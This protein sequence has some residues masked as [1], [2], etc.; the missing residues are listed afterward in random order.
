MGC[1][2]ALFRCQTV[3][4]QLGDAF[5]TSKPSFTH[6][7]GRVKP[8]FHHK[9]QNS[10]KRIQKAKILHTGKN[11]LCFMYIY[12]YIHTVTGAWRGDMH[13]YLCVCLI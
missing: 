13:V 3:A 7:S 10:L 1:A 11:V 12:I 8:P 2:T 4:L 9:R 5:Q 6:R